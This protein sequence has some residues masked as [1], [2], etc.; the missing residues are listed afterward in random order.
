M[1]HVQYSEGRLQTYLEDAKSGLFGSGDAAGL[2]EA[3]QAVFDAILRMN[4]KGM[5][6]TIKNI[7]ELF[8]KK[9]YGWPLSAIQAQ[10]AT[11][12][13][14]GK[15]E[16]KA[17]SNM[18]NDAGFIEALRNTAKHSNVILEPQVDFTP[19]QVRALT[20]FYKDYFDSVAPTGDPKALALKTSDLLKEEAHML[21][22]LQAQAVNYPFLSKLDPVIA[23][24]KDVSDKP[25]K[26]FLLSLSEK[27]DALLDAKE[28]VVA[29][30]RKF[31][32]GPQKGIFDDARKF[33]SDEA[34]NLIGDPAAD[35]VAIRTVLDDPAVYRGNA[36]QGLKASVDALRAKIRSVVDEV[37]EESV[38]KIQVLKSRVEGDE[39]LSKLPEAAQANL[40]NAFDA[41]MSEVRAGKVVPII[42][43]IV[44][45]FE[46]EEYPRLIGQLAAAGSETEPVPAAGDG[47]GTPAP[48]VSEPRIVPVRHV[49]V[50][51]AQALLDTEGDV[52]AYVDALRDA[53]KAEIRS[54]KKVSV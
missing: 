51:H 7:T 12:F 13:G 10:L 19:A 28:D 46:D 39:K 18:L 50:P 34:N 11:L 6:A 32:D 14:R 4:N 44:R 15:I 3:E 23:D 37:R 43:D 29:P 30:I 33:L 38:G 24:L 21:Q 20:E 49:R 16:A 41:A 42:R 1:L 53:L 40:L 54:G 36:V 5:R 26:W 27:S 52:D 25:Y 35:A 9:P 48:G 17:D 31:M 8:E 47:A 45:R 2:T 22:R